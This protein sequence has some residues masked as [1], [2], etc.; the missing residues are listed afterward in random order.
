[1]PS[2]NQAIEK[3]VSPTYSRDQVKHILNS[4]NSL[5]GGGSEKYLPNKVKFGDVCRLE[6]THGVVAGKP[7]PFA[8]LKV[9]GEECIC[10]PLSSTEDWNTLVKGESRFFKE[11]IFT[12]NI[13]ILP[14]QMVI[15]SFVAPYDNRKILI[16]VKKQLK[17]YYR[18]FL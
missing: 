14:T 5:D 8:V 9:I 13:V 16:E 1:M 10:V 18:G 3:L 17:K 6:S 4:I 2:R 7:R 15:N 11:S 12:K